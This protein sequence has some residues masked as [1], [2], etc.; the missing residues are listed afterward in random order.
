MRIAHYTGNDEVINDNIDQSGDK[1]VAKLP[2]KKLTL[3]S[4]P[5]VAFEQF[6]SFEDG[7]NAV[8]TGNKNEPG[9]DLHTGN[10]GF[11]SAIAASYN[12]AN[13]LRR[14]N[15]GGNEISYVVFFPNHYGGLGGRQQGGG[16]ARALIF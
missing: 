14:T 6:S 11:K 15:I 12:L 3:Y 7:F 9:S 4:Y 1:M 16:S 2:I 10:G 8:Y 5:S 13:R